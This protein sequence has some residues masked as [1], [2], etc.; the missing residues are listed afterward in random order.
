[1][2]LGHQSDAYRGASLVTRRSACVETPADHA[3]RSPGL[4]SRGHAANAA[5]GNRTV[6]QMRAAAMSAIGNRAVTR[7]QVRL[8]C[9]LSPSLQRI[10]VL[11]S[12]MPCNY[13]IKTGF[14][15]VY[16]P[17]ELRRRG[18]L[19]VRESPCSLPR[20]RHTSHT[21]RHHKP[22]PRSPTPSPQ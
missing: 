22:P 3:A 20:R 6:A 13:Y 16:Q 9:P 17:K 8:W 4:H 15:S 1:M 10:Q 18:A 11:S 19:E 5:D 7:M 14:Q 12:L 21:L 2:L